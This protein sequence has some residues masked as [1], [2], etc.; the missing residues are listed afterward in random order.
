ML[1][2]VPGARPGQMP[3]IVLDAGTEARLLHHLDIKIGPL[4]DSLSLQKL[5][6]A[7]EITNLLFQFFLDVNGCFFDLFHRQ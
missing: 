3:G 7:L 4:R 5:I 1:G 2:G 6:L